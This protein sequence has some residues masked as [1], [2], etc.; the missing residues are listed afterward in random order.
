MSALP[1]ARSAAS[2]SS[3]APA[4]IRA[5]RTDV[6]AYGEGFIGIGGKEIV[7]EEEDFASGMRNNVLDYQALDADNDGQLDF[8]TDAQ[9]TISQ[10]RLF[11]FN[12]KRQTASC[13]NASSS[14]K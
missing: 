7:F 8:P 14:I 9:K 12:G 13:A 6:A 1:S 10:F 5:E 4:P 2:S 3:A 11:P